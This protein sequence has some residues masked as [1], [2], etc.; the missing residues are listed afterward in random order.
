VSKQ[1][2]LKCEPSGIFALCRWVNSPWRFEE[3]Y[4]LILQDQVVQPMQEDSFGLQNT[5]D[6]GTKRLENF[7]N[8]LPISLPTFQR[9]EVFIHDR[10]S[11]ILKKF[12]DLLHS[13]TNYGYDTCCIF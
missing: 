4:Y 7:R 13:F 12:E 2:C 9:T 5:E 1:R 3:S 8:Y 6:E 11:K 10:L